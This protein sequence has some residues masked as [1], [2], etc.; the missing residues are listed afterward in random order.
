MENC[1]ESHITQLHSNV[2]RTHATKS[3]NWAQT[4]ALPFTVSPVSGVAGVWT[5]VDVIFGVLK[6]VG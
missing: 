2:F 4:A 1:S 6:L 5:N 3:E